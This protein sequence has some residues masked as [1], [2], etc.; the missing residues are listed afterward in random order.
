[1]PTITYRKGPLGYA[2]LHDGV[3]VG[4]I[5]DRRNF[6]CWQVSVPNLNPANAVSD[7]VLFQGKTTFATLAEAKKAVEIALTASTV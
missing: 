2:V 1:M 5:S 7:G 6:K 4:R 3:A